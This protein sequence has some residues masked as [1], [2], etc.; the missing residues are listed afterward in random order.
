MHS[1]KMVM[2]SYIKDI[3]FDLILPQVKVV[4]HRQALLTMAQEAAD[5]LSISEK[6]IFSR[7]SDKEDLGSS[8]V[9]DGVAIPHLKMRRARIAFSMLMTLETPVKDD[10]GGEAID[11]YSLIISP[12]EDGPLHLRRLSRISRLLKNETLHKRLRETYDRDVMQALFV[13]PEGWLLA[14]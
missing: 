12:A 9:G 8:A 3:Q 2:S 11:I 6:R 13:D 1:G 7:L 14:A 5:Y 4:S 10:R